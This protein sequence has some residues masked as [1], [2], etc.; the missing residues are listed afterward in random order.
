TQVATIAGTS[1]VDTGAPEGVTSTYTV[2]AKDAAGNV[3]A[4]SGPLS[5]LYQDVTAPSVPSNVTAPSPSGALPSLRW[6]AS[7][8]PDDAIASYTV[9]RDGLP[10]GTTA[11]PSFIDQGAP[12]GATFSYTVIATDTHGNV[13][14]ASSP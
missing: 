2:K 3:S 11:S 8:D 9:L 7:T 6:Q 13:S 12:Y 1:F 5:I 14:A 4:S 10:V